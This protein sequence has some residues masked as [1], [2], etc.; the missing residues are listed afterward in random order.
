MRRGPSWKQLV[1]VL[2]AIGAVVVVSPALGGPSLKT[3]DSLDRAKQAAH[4]AKKKKSKPGPAGP[5]GPAGPGGAAGAA[6]AAGSARAFAA[7]QNNVSFVTGKVKGFTAVNRP[8]TGEYC[9]TPAAGIDPSTT[10]PVASADFGLSV[11]VDS[12]ALARQSAAD[13]TPG[14]FEVITEVAGA[15]S[16]TPGFTVMVP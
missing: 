9:L 15:V 11:S 13:C 7:V 1:I 10:V 5:Q 3:H 14:Q 6:G 12:A 2:A 8:G 4:S 16:N